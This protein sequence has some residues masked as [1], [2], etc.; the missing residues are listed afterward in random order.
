MLRID[1]VGKVYAD[2]TRAL[3]DI[4][5]EV[6]R[7]EILVLLGASGCGKTTLLRIIA[8]LESASTGSVALDGRR[9]TEP[10]P[11]I[12]LAFQ[13][14]RLL[15][16]LTVAENVG[17]G[18]RGVSRA[19]REARVD[20]ILERVGLA[21]QRGKLPR[22]LSGGQQQRVALA[23][24]LVVEPEVLLLDEPFSALDALTRES[25]QDHLLQLWAEDAPT[26][27]MVTHDIEEAAVL[28]DRIVV[29]D[30]HPGRIAEIVVNAAE[31]PR[32]RDAADVVALRRRLR[33]ALDRGER[34]EEPLLMAV[35]DPP[36]RSSARSRIGAG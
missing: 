6:P 18:L 15:P 25:L 9:I 29:L 4:S 12:G 24:A 21:A 30:A 32:R 28:A 22:D 16:W 13:E 14:A 26:I 3:V 11:G 33:S 7:G 20:A 19:L 36:T 1:R 5:L 31:R 27:V 23:R 10:H 17:F 8:G 34:G 2:G 35:N